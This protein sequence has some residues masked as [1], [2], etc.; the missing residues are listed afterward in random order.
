MKTTE[1]IAI[2]AF[3]CTIIST[4]I[5]LLTLFT[6]FRAAVNLLTEQRIYQLG[7]SELSLGPWKSKVSSSL[8]LNFQSKIRTP[9]VSLPMLVKQNREEKWD[10]RF[11]FPKGFTCKEGTSRADVETGLSGKIQ[12][13]ASWVNFLQALSIEPQHEKLLYELRFE[14]AI[15]NGIV[16]MRWKSKDLV[17]ICSVLGFQTC[18]ENPSYK[19][20][21]PLPTRWSGPLG[22]LQ[23][24]QSSDGCIAEFRRRVEL[25]HQLS[26]DAFF[27]FK[28][29]K[30][31]TR[32][33][34]LE[35]RLWQ[36]FNGFFLKG[37][38]TLYIGGAD[39]NPG[40]Q[41]GSQR[42]PG[43]QRMRESSDAGDQEDNS[44]RSPVINGI[45]QELQRASLMEVDDEEEDKDRMIPGEQEDNSTPDADGK[46]NNGTVPGQQRASSVEANDDQEVEE[47][48]RGRLIPRDLPEFLQEVLFFFTSSGNGRRTG[49]FDDNG[50]P[51]LVQVLSRCKGLLSVIMEGELAHS[52]GLDTSNCKEYDRA[53]IASEDWNRSTHPY[54]MGN[55]CMDE[56]LLKLIKEAVMELKPDGFYFT[57]TKYLFSDVIEFY[58]HVHRQSDTL[59]KSIFPVSGVVNWRDRDG[60]IWKTLYYAMELCNNFQRSKKAERA[61]FTVEDM[62]IVSKAGESL[63]SIAEE[64]IDLTWAFIIS[65]EFFK[66]IFERFGRMTA[67]EVDTFVVTC[68]GE[69][70][71]ET[72][73]LQ[74]PD[75]A[76]PV[77]LMRTGR[78]E[79]FQVL[80]ALVDVFLTYF[81]IQKCWITDI[82]NYDATIPQSVTM[83]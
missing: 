61:Y 76:F 26:D 82:R 40:A 9:R 1:Y 44:T 46:D 34:R 25:Q 28:N 65:P 55:I 73:S 36:C 3:V 11:T 42:R 49:G 80:A 15:V 43:S 33:F 31:R 59:D 2:F 13:G 18:E 30:I 52:W 63:R 83:C 10:A 4:T 69:R 38:C 71:R 19:A 70:L 21:M 57:P 47:I 35:A 39:E 8:G 77:P 48:R 5:S 54:R 78:Y 64:V 56:G 60:T 72:I 62:V 58:R 32:P 29:L 68:E 14:A 16:P 66:E 24:R 50:V 20:P 17:G 67:E 74:S 75:K 12:M 41:S 81:W 53:Y 51:R 6:L 37:N 7:L 27:Y 79:S 23:F 22:W 45:V